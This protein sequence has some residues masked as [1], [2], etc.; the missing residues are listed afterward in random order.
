[1]G[2]IYKYEKEHMTILR[3]LSPEC[4][5]LLKYNGSFPLEKAGKIALYGSGARKTVKGGTGSGDV[6]VRHFTTIEEGLE[7]AGFTVTTKNW[8]DAYDRVRE[9]AHHRFVQEIK[10]KAKEAGIPAILFG[11]G[12]VMPEPDYELPMEGEGDTAIYV[13]ARISG[14]GSDRKD[15]EGDYRLTKTEIRDILSLSRQYDRFLLVLNTGG[16]LDLTPVMEISNIL[17]LS[18]I[19][20]T[21]GDS[22]AD[23]LLGRAYPSGKLAATWGGEK[24]GIIG[25]FAESD[26]TR[27][28]EGVYVGYRYFDSTGEEPLFP[29]GYGLSYTTFTSFVRKIY[30]DGT[31]VTVRVAVTNT[32]NLLGKEVLQ[33]YVSV[34]SERLD[35][36]Y[37]TLAAFAKTKELRPGE[38]QE[39]VL[40]FSIEGL[41]SFDTERSVE[42]LELGDYILRIGNSSRTT[43]VC[44]VIRLEK[45]IIVSSLAHAGG[46][47][48]FIDWKPDHS[49]L[50]QEKPKIE[51]KLRDGQI[52]LL[53][54]DIDEWRT[55]GALM[56]SSEQRGDPEEKALIQLLDTM[57]NSELAYLCIGRYLDEGSKSIVGNAGFA[58]AGS[59]GETTRLY[60]AQGIPGLVMADGPAGL[61]LSRQYGEDEHGV[62]TVGDEIPAAFLDF[63]DEQALALMTN[64]KEEKKT[65]MERYT[66]SIVR[67]SL[68]ERHWHRVGIL[69]C[70]KS[71][72]K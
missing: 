29:F 11:M 53:L 61:R 63:I 42:I 62:Y 36:P 69:I 47:A 22:F 31:I 49:L 32:G 16:P 34:P 67:Q 70:A 24:L 10:K 37:Q 40:K 48:D 43:E 68:S 14:E 13:L 59:A 39:V 27:Y 44:G 33:L 45:E 57:S 4:M 66:T 35:Q 2:D 38:T 26:D 60:E 5:V 20:M 65:E 56:D 46:E 1:M 25:D 58:V 9:A 50:V 52:P 7:K 17:L 8:L 6:N 18:Q 21:I 41:A 12:A 28:R 51:Q 15:I 71:A 64:G 23:V 54:G 30:L 72:G 3:R 55:N 19:G